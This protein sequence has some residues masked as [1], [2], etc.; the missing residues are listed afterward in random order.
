MPE[1]KPY[2]LIYSEVQLV[3]SHTVSSTRLAR[4]RTNDL[5]QAVT[6]GAPNSFP[7]VRFIF[8]GHPALEGEFEGGKTIEVE[9]L[10]Y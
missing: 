8:E 4:I 10:I 6:E 3:G 7:N 9:D 2:T 5:K 1:L